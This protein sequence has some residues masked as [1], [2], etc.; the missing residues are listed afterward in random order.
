MEFLVMLLAMYLV[1]MLLARGSG[2]LFNNPT[3]P[4][5]VARALALIISGAGLALFVAVG[6]QTE[7]D[8]Q[9]I[10][11]AGVFMSFLVLSLP[12]WLA[13]MLLRERKPRPTEPNGTGFSKTS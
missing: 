10:A 4:P 8:A 9:G 5:R 1:T 6:S 2:R 12:S 3:L 7:S 13:Y 11:L